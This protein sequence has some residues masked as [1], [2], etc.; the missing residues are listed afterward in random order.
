MCS[1][2]IEEMKKSVESIRKKM[3]LVIV[4]VLCWFYFLLGFGT[5]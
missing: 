3:K 4:L 2:E 1:K 5:I